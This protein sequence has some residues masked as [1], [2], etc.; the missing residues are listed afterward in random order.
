MSYRVVARIDLEGLAVDSEHLRFFVSI[1]T[2]GDGFI[3][4]NRAYLVAEGD[5]LGWIDLFEYVFL[6]YKFFLHPDSQ[7]A[8]DK[9]EVKHLVASID[10]E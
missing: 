5:D 1:L 9:R 2:D 6:N 8:S 10:Q 4:K 3:Q 7:D